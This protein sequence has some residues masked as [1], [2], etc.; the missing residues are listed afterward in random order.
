MH[1][2]RRLLQNRLAHLRIPLGLVISKRVQIL[3]LQQKNDHHDEAGASPAIPAWRTA[4]R[5]E[6]ITTNAATIML[7]CSTSSCSAAG[8]RVRGT[9]SGP[10]RDMPA[11]RNV[12]RVLPW[13]GSNLRSAVRNGIAVAPR[14]HLRNQSSEG[15]GISDFQRSR[16]GAMAKDVRFSIHPI[17][18]PMEWQPKGYRQISAVFGVRL[19][20]SA[21]EREQGTRQGWPRS[22]GT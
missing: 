20:G 4:A 3:Q 13:G 19:S 22:Y 6:R 10:T 7:I 21:T 5:Q 16:I 9:G 17:R 14:V 11:Q 15:R 8:V 18:A 12:A 2:A 1:A